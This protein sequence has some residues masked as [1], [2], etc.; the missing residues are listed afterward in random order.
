MKNYLIKQTATVGRQA[1]FVES[2]LQKPLSSDLA[3]LPT[4]L[5]QLHRLH[6][7]P[8]LSL[9]RDLLFLL[10][11]NETL[12][13]NAPLQPLLAHQGIQNL[14]DLQWPVAARLGL[15]ALL[16]HDIPFPNWQPP[17]ELTPTYLREHLNIALHGETIPPQAPSPP[18]AALQTAADNID[19]RLLSLLSLLGKEAVETEPSLPLRLAQQ[20]SQLPPLTP[21]QRKWLGIKLRLDSGSRA[22]GSGIGTEHAGVTFHGSL[23]ALLPSQ[24]ALPRPLFYSRHYRNELLY[25]ARTGQEPPRLRPTILVLDISPSCF[26]PVEALTRLAA[27][28]IA[29]SLQQAQLPVVLITTDPLN[30]VQTLEQPAHLLA[31]WTQ[32]SLN[33]V[34]IKRTLSVAQKLREN[35]HEG[36]IA[37]AIL[38]LTHT[39]FANGQHLSPPKGLR[40]LFVQYPKHSQIKPPFARYCERWES[41]ANGQL[42]GF[43][44]ILGRLVG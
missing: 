44:E 18:I 29:T 17:P 41:I 19:D 22:Q 9:L 30:T 34:P 11:K 7:Y 40:A 8:P 25:R 37:P 3:F 13:D 2:D 36:N 33:P 21:Q 42:T 16:L 38:L 23:S 1:I 26:G 15:A 43:E 5:S 39:Q 35:L 10:R 6:C 4:A 28:I 32:R 20:V 27:H 14:R 24:L 12:E 31:I